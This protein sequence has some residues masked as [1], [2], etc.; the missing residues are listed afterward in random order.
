MKFVICITV[1]LF[2]FSCGIFKTDSLFKANKEF[3]PIGSAVEPDQLSG[4]ESEIL[5]KHYNS[6]TAENAMKYLST[7]PKEGQ[8]DFSQADK[9][10]AFAEKHGKKVRGHC[11]IWII[12][13]KSQTGC[14]RTRT[15]NRQA[16]N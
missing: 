16:E 2:L 3:F 11:L 14:F 7:E 4:P 15:E 13:L 6:I 5:I 8:F 1:S 12:P 9:I 10:M